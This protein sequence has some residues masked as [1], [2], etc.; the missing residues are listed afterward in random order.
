[1]DCFDILDDLSDEFEL[2][3]YFMFLMISEPTYELDY[4]PIKRINYYYTIFPIDSYEHTILERVA[5]YGDLKACQRLVKLG[6][7]ITRTVV[8]N[9]CCCGNL[10]LVQWIRGMTKKG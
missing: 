7:R 10:E 5:Q 4:N 9:A 2:L 3:D 1:M 8:R 6:E